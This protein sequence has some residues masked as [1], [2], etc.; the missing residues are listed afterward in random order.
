MRG[1]VPYYTQYG[2]PGFGEDKPSEYGAIA[3]FSL[4]AV[5]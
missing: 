4:G 2:E 3:G 5:I 1:S